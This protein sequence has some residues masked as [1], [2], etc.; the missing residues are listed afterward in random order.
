VESGQGFLFARAVPSDVFEQRY[1]TDAD[2][3][4]KA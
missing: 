1:L 2:N 3:H 4:A